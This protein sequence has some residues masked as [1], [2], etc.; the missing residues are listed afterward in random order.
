MYLSF[1]WDGTD[2]GQ[3][4]RHHG[5]V[6]GSFDV[7]VSLWLICVLASHNLG[8]S[9]LSCPSSSR[10]VPRPWPTVRTQASAKPRRWVIEVFSFFFLHDAL[11]LDGKRSSCGEGRMRGVKKP[12]LPIHLTT[13]NYLTAR[14]RR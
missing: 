2:Y 4:R 1:S 12:S 6:M 5:I 10:L 8:A 14:R 3:W 11:S 7:K 13:W 9:P